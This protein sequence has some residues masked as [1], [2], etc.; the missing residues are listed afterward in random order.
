[1]WCVNPHTAHKGSCFSSALLMNIRT[2]NTNTCTHTNTNTVLDKHTNNY[3]CF[4]ITM[5]IH[6]E[7]KDT[8]R[9]DIQVINS[10]ILQIN[11]LSAPLALHMLYEYTR[12]VDIQIIQL[13]CTNTV[14]IL[15]K[16]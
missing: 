3:S 14:D 12:V 6:H 2:K 4:A 8:E 16:C 1:M 13:R 7:L 11:I 15:Y 5:I 9:K 10:N